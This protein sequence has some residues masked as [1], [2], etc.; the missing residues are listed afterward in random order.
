MIAVNCRFFN[1]ELSGT[2]RFAYEILTRLVKFYP[3][4]VLLTPKLKKPPPEPFRKFR[5]LSGK[6][7]GHLWEQFELHFQLKKMG[8]PLLINLLNS[9]PLV[10]ENQIVTVHDLSFLVNPEWFSKKYYLYYRVTTPLF[11][12][13]SKKIITVSHFSKNEI[14]KIFN[15]DVNKIH[16]IYNGVSQKF[17]RAKKSSKKNYILAIGGSN[18]R[19][20]IENIIRALDNVSLKNIYLVA[21]SG[22]NKIFPSKNINLPKL[23]RV[24]ILNRVTDSQLVKLYSEASVFVFPSLYEG[25]GIP[26]LEAMACGTPV[27]VSNA[28]SLPEV[29]GD[30]ALYVNPNDP[31]D[32]AR[33]I[34]MILEDCRLREE[35]IRKGMERAK[36]FSWDKSAIKLK[37]IID[38]IL[39]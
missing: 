32:I 10:Y 35:L 29:C 8:S 23:N 5:I 22:Q 15:V 4:I 2:Q 16:V 7:S 30:A 11:L 39:E 36:L 27:V 24:Q 19:K 37:N 6:L 18:P 34:N 26:P 33:K 9:A 31:V 17:F 12:K 21:V 14:L 3:D 1:Q 13:R 38:S 20:N 25:F 28:S